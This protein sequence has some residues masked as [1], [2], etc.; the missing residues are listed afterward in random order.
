MTHDLASGV[1]TDHVYEDVARGYDLARQISDEV[2]ASRWEC[3]ATHI[4]TRGEGI[5]LVVFN[6]L[7]WPRA[8]VA[9]VTVGFAEHGVQD[10]ALVD[11]AGKEMPVQ[12]LQA[13]HYGDGGIQQGRICFVARDIPALGYAT[14][15]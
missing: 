3:I 15:R 8:D 10:I 14:D 1:M 5:P 6:T 2:I 11:P 9:E 7:G 4:D 12:I 13:D